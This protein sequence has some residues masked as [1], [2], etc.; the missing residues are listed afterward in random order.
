M[1]KTALFHRFLKTFSLFICCISGCPVTLT[2][3]GLSLVAEVLALLFTAVGGL[4]S[5]LTSPAAEHRLYTTGSAVA[6]PRLRDSWGVWNLSR[7]GINPTP[8]PTLAGRF[9]PTDS[10]GKSFL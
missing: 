8:V 1:Y 7:P 2:L 10:P 4:L 6:V 3:R 5:A 9:L